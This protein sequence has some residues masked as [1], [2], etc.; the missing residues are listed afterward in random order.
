MMEAPASLLTRA[1]SM[2]PP[3]WRDARLAIHFALTL[4]VGG[5]GAVLSLPT[6]TF[7]S[8]AF[9]M[10]AQMGNEIHWAMALWLVAMIGLMGMTTASKGVRLFSVLVLA[11]AHGA[12]GICFALA[13]QF[14][15]GAITY[16]VIAGLGYY[17]AWRR[18]I[19]GV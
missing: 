5:F 17:L 6:N 18:S 15:T 8:P 12:L 4:I 11:T 1:I 14:G 13:P 3:A 2:T 9:T 16:I 19:E 10:L 7:G